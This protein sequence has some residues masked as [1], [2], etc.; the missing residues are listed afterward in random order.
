MKS[1]GQRESFF[2]SL[3]AW[4][5]VPTTLKIYSFSVLAYH[6]ILPNR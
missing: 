1:L 6:K 5:L 4:A 2:Y 3:V